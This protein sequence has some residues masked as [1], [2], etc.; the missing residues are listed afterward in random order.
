M[1]QV[2]SFGENI[3]KSGKADKFDHANEFDQLLVEFG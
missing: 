3:V 1:N 2:C